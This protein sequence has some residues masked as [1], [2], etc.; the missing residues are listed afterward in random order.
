[1][2]ILVYFFIH[3]IHCY[4]YDFFIKS[5]GANILLFSNEL[6]NF[7]AGL[8]AP[9]AF[10]FLI[11]GYYLQ[12]QTI[13]QNK[14]ES[15]KQLAIL[16]QEFLSQQKIILFN[17]QPYFHVE[18]LKIFKE[19]VSNSSPILSITFT[20]KNSRALCRSLFLCI[21]LGMEIG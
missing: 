13:K 6:G 18:N 16:K 21:T 17:A 12:N 15:D 14:I 20:L 11:L 3:F 10:L 9:L 2:V 4:I 19:Y 5:D 8:F 7:L 1:M